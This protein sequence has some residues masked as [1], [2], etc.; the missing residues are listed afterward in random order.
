MRDRLPED[1]APSKGPRRLTDLPPP[2]ASFLRPGD[3]SPAVLEL[4]GRSDV[5]V[6][7]LAIRLARLARQPESGQRFRPCWV[8]VGTAGTAA[9][10]LFLLGLA[11]RLLHGRP[12]PVLY[13]L[14]SADPDYF[15]DVLVRECRKALLDLP[16]LVVVD[17]WADTG[18]A[19]TAAR[20]T[21]GTRCRVLLMSKARRRAATTGAV[22]YEVPAGAD[23]GEARSGRADEAP[24]DRLLLAAALS[25]S[26]NLTE[27]ADACADLA[28]RLLCQGDPDSAALLDLLEPHLVG[29]QGLFRLLR[30]KHALLGR[31]GNWE[32]LRTVIAAA[33]RETGR[34]LPAVDVL[35]P[36]ATARAAR[37]TAVARRH[38]GAL[39]EA[40][41]TL[42]TIPDSTPPDGWA[43][44]TRAAVLCDKGEPAGAER[45]LRSAVEAHQVRGDVRGEAW[46]IH[47][48]GRQRL[49]RG[50]LEEARKHLETAR[51]MF[52]GLGDQQGRAWSTT[53]LGRAQL[54]HGAYG[55]AV[56][57]L[58]KGLGL[59]LS[60]QDLRG[61]YW[62]YLYLALAHAESD[63]P[64]QAT[65]LV[66]DAAR[67]FHRIP[68]LLGVAWAR[69]FHAI[70]LSGVP[71][72]ADK[73]ES[74]LRSAR[75][76]FRQAGCRHGEA[77][78]LLEL[79]ELRRKETGL[80]GGTVTYAQARRLFAA[81]GDE[82]T[83][84]WTRPLPLI[85]SATARFPERP[86]LLARLVVPEPGAAFDWGVLIPAAHSLVRLT[87]HDE[88]S[89]AGT[90]SRIALHIDPGPDHPWSTPTA[91]HPWLTARAT[92]LTAADVEPAHAVTLKP[93]PR[94]PDGAEFLFT[95]RRAG[96]HR[97]LFTVED[98]ATATVLQ[99]VET[100]IDVTDGEAGTP[101]AA[102]SPE[103]LRRA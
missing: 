23:S 1:P 72:T 77:W 92:P 52:V 31:T 103:A 61:K 66:R 42:D 40:M 94:D 43:L 55:E 65:P 17:G 2:L 88:R 4:Y 27:E 54:L 9:P 53:E 63:A 75:A 59:H 21:E 69:H 25:G 89:T 46:A 11:E 78:S 58:S 37:E 13:E 67:N 38:A 86:P 28:V 99:Q 30:L 60:N 5:A 48:Y 20:L 50:A 101:D 85:T 8:T 79:A 80:G 84:R 68:D 56:H 22:G 32:P 29:R 100:Y 3:E 45:L 7:R 49:I 91:D 90:A 95:P 18:L 6:F 97:L 12:P 24:L 51:H 10:D 64:A 26:L 71:G 81:I 74:H 93:S 98:S 34:P 76:G 57:T 73:A 36:L 83:R 14:L 33:V 82:S 35:A 15:T 102:G 96:R 19:G 87:L 62:T 44:H 47:H 70:L 39:G 16:C 41:A